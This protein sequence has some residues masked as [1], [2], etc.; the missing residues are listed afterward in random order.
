MYVIAILPEL[1]ML[2]AKQMYSFKVPLSRSG[3]ARMENHFLPW[4]IVICILLC[5]PC[6]AE[7]L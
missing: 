2:K 4:G 5:L 1:L 3:T 7:R 6:W